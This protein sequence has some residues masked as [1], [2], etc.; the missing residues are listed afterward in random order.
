MYLC[1]V[2]YLAE[3]SSLRKP[4][5]DLNIFIHMWLFRKK[6]DENGLRGLDREIFVYSLLLNQSRYL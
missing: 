5:E 4:Y 3:S 6:V 1:T 2:N